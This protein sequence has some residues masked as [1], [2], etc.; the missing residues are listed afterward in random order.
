MVGEGVAQ[1]EDT[2][3]TAGTTKAWQ[4]QSWELLSQFSGKHCNMSGQEL[5]AHAP[6]WQGTSRAKH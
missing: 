6:G 1:A 4:G 5:G 3:G 2:T